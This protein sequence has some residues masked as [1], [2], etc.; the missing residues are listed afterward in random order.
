MHYRRYATV[1]FFLRILIIA[2]FS[3][4][5]ESPHDDANIEVIILHILHL[6]YAKCRMPKKWPSNI[7]LLTLQKKFLRI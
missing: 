1:Y 4:I 5:H 3:N 2:F 6:A 7:F